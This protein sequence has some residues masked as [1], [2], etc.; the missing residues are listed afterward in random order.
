MARRPVRPPPP[1]YDARDPEQLWAL[2]NVFTVDHAQLTREML[3][4]GD[5]AVTLLTEKLSEDPHGWRA[6]LLLAA[7][8]APAAD[9][10]IP[11]LTLHMNAHRDAPTRAWCARALGVLQRLDALEPL[12]QSEAQRELTV[13]AEGLK[14]ARPASYPML[15]R[16]LDQGNGPLNGLLHTALKPGSASFDFSAAQVELVLTAMRSTHITLR[17]DAVCNAANVAKSAHKS[18]SPAV[19]AALSDEDMHVRRL[20]VLMLGRMGKRVLASAIEPVRALAQDPNSKVRF[21]VEHV[22]TKAKLA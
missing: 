11:A 2:F 9:A 21:A 5:A 14:A 16:A 1:A 19:I 8:G 17:R 3:A 7:F 10:A 15:Q 4:I 12:L 6:A 13:L 20:A 22:L 18:L